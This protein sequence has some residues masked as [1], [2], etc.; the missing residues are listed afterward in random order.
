MIV[1]TPEMRA[2]VHAKDC[3]DLGHLYD[4]STMLGHDPESN[5][6]GLRG[7]TGKVAHLSCSRC[8]AVWI[9]MPT[10]GNGY[11]E[12]LAKVKKRLDRDEEL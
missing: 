12:A 5:R 4:T 3:E 7:P 1:V 2:A 11:D 8:S 9:V 6:R 10:P